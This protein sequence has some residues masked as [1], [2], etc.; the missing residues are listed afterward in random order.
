MVSPDQLRPAA[1]F[2]LGATSVKLAGSQERFY[3]STLQ[4]GTA[5]FWSCS[6][7]R[8]ADNHCLSLFLIESCCMQEDM[9]TAVLA[10][11]RT[12]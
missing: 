2:L 9:L 11:K 10:F 1:Y 5:C 8:R 3:P 12:S 7:A 4:A 6:F